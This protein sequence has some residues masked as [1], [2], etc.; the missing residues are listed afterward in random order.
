MAIGREAT[1]G[2]RLRQVLAPAHNRERRAAQARPREP[3]PRA[4]RNAMAL[5][6]PERIG[7]FRVVG[8]LG[9]G[10]M[11]VVYRGRDDV[12]ER[13]VALKVM[14]TAA[15]GDADNRQRFLREAR[16][17]ARLQHP[18]IVTI[19]ELGEH[20][21]QPFMALELLEGL[22]LQRAIELGIRHDPKVI[23]PVMLQ[24]L[25]GLGH[26]HAHGV[27][28]RDVKPSNV[29]I[30][31]ARPVKLMDF[32]VARLAATTLTTTGTVLGTP[33]YMSPEQVQGGQVDG[34]SDLFS[35]GLILY[36]LLTGE[37][38]FR[39]G[40]VVAVLYKIAHEPPDL[41]LLPAGGPWAALRA[42]VERVLAHDPATRHP[43]AG[44]L[45]Q[46]LL[47]VLSAL[48]GTPEWSAA[49]DISL[50]TRMAPRPRA[51]PAETW[52]A[53]PTEHAASPGGAPQVSLA[54]A[55]GSLT[56][57]P[58]V[59]DP[60]TLPATP[61]DSL[62]LDSGGSG[63]RDVGR[64]LSD[65]TT[66]GRVR[67]SWRS[68]AALVI[69][70]LAVTLLV[71][72]ALVGRGPGPRSPASPAATAAA[73]AVVPTARSASA[74]PP[75]RPPST[76]G[77]TPA[78]VVPAPASPAPTAA[79]PTSP[80]ATPRPTSTPVPAAASSASPSTPPVDARLEH[81]ER[82]LEQGRYS[83]ALNEAKAVLE[84]APDTE[85]AR[86]IVQEAEA[87][88]LVESSLKNA[89]EAWSQGD[90]ERTRAELQ[91]GLAVRPNDAR[92]LALWRKLKR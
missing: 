42:V 64:T 10:A 37:K 81:A 46:D 3:F 87:L 60:A 56:D 91:K 20:D 22:D 70:G 57:L 89:R 49:P 79:P 52:R 74:P 23:L 1:Q 19:Y 29:F 54:R 13:D 26:A 73:P 25:A 66:T 11:G 59:H 2:A 58:L 43:D 76:P 44:A 27:V 33:S 32:G 14:A 72:L 68:P 40:S 53:A 34:R 41:S 9:Q 21:G 24:M 28:H 88:L 39:A 71:V 4:N 38:A 69:A 65:S 67:P 51:S 15:L 35:A 85:V 5:P 83:S 12:L 8:L 82:L 48:G 30:P 50:L 63:S 75:P 36:E 17:S 90:R 31:Y 47:R 84:R 92:L 55:T 18:N 86:D 80:P 6:L 77:A 62:A 7:R 61:A 45:S 16:A 78:V